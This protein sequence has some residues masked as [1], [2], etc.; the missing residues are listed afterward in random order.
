MPKRS[1]LT[2]LVALLAL[3]AVALGTRL[4]ALLAARSELVL[5]IASKPGGAI[6]AEGCVALIDINRADRALLTELSGIGPV[7]A[8]RIVRY[9]EQNGSYPS[10][11]ALTLVDG[12]GDKLLARIRDQVCAGNSN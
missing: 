2:L 9:R 4:P 10:V 6:R 3:C 7:L 8:D 11:E 12:I 5:P 1:D